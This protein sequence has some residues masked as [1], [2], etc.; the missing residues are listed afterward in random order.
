MADEAL[1]QRAQ[2][3][4]LLQ[5]ARSDHL[6]TLR[7][8]L[9][10]PGYGGSFLRGKVESV[11]DAEKG[12]KDFASFPDGQILPP[13]LTSYLAALLLHLSRAWSEWNREKGSN[14]DSNHI[15]TMGKNTHKHLANG[16]MTVISSI[17]PVL[18]MVILFFI[19]RLLIR[20]ILI[21]VFTNV[22]AATLVFG[23]RIGPDQTLAITTA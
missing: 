17:L 16:I 20:L 15:Y 10:R 11:W 14:G 6:R 13:R 23:M 2:I 21:L 7:K 5:T 3:R 18:P 1:I 22:F 4:T 19:K 8:W 12:F 9:E